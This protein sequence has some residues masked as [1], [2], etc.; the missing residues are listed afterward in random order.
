VTLPGLPAEGRE[1]SGKVAL[2]T[3]GAKNIGKAI[4]LALAS[5]GASIAVNTQHSREDADALVAQIRASGGAAEVY[6]ADIADGAAVREMGE[7]VVKRFGRVDILVLNASIRREVLFKEM[8]FEQW[9]TAMSIT[10]DGSFHCIKACLPSM[11]AS[12]GGT[13]VTIGGDGA[14]LG[15]VR[16]AHN[17]AAKNGLV[18]LTR[19]LAKELAGDG[20]RVNCVSPGNINTT[21]P[22]HRSPRAEAKGTIP[23][24]RW[25]ESE[26]IASVV[27][28][29]CGPG[30]GFITGQVIHV[31]GG[32]MMFA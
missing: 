32:Q 9:R 2:V 24:G 27:R 8:T 17:S 1:L 28:F 5:G 4:S 6:M 16:K 18:G 21:R 31:N 11:I 3:G 23:L 10:L 26:E 22:S 20:I 14:L 25:G 30:G 12:G 15:S 19:A 29:L 7:A 13:I